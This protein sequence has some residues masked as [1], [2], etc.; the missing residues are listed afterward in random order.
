MDFPHFSG[1]YPMQGVADGFHSPRNT[2]PSGVHQDNHGHPPVRH[3]LLMPDALVRGDQSIESRFFGLIQ[4][5]PVGQGVPSV[6]PGLFDDVTK[7]SAAQLPG[8]PVIE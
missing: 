7:E 3:I 5:I 6:L 2:R 1:L 4:Q 8:S